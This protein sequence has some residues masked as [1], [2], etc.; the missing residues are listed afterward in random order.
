[1]EDDALPLQMVLIPGGTFT[2]GSPEDEPDREDSEG[3]QHQ[4][5][6]PAFFMGRYPITQAQYASLMETNPATAYNADRFVAPDKPVIG[7]SWEDAVAFCDRLTTLTDRPYRLPSEA[8][9]EYACRAGTQTPF[10]VGHTLTDELANYNASEPYGGGPIGRYRKE[11]TL[12]SSS[13]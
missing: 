5:T 2:M 10:Y 12:F 13:E 1:M 3:P 9:W 4:V 11:T 7:V 8:E 6:V